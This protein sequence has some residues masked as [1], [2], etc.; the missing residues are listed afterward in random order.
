MKK[1]LMGLCA[2]AAG[3]VFTGCVA[4]TD[5]GYGYSG[6]S[7]YPATY[8]SP[9][10]VTGSIYIDGGSYYDGGNWRRHPGRW[11]R[12]GYSRGRY[13]GYQGYERGGHGYWR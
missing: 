5:P 8:V 10:P 9:T 12:G 13:G 7:D 11:D 6:Y 2:L 3:F 1:V 4:T